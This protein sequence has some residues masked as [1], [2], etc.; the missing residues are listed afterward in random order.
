MDLPRT[1]TVLG[2]GEIL[3]DCFPDGRRPGGAPANQAF[4][5]NQL[6]AIGIVA[7]RVGQDPLGDDLLKVLEERGLSTRLIQ[8]DPELPT[9]TVTVELGP[10]GEPSYEIHE[11]V[12][13]DRMELTPELDSLFGRLDA[14]CFGTLAQRSEPSRRCIQQVLDRA[15]EAIRLYDVNLRQNFFTPE[16]L[17]QSLERA[18]MVKLNEREAESLPQILSL[19]VRGAADLARWLHDEFGTSLLCITRSEQGCLLA[20]PGRV[21]EIPGVPADVK[22]TVGAG[23]A[24]TAALLTTLLDGWPL[25]HAGLFANEVG[26][27][28]ASSAGA[29]PRLDNKLEELRARHQPE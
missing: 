4:H 16:I 7:S 13:W 23:D 14:I 20:E 29:M 15:G 2:L 12:A 24:F 11:P 21:V 25:E 10:S 8:R 3:W 5:A 18:N 17:R 28:V 22:D 6:G 19:G 1:P 27:L 26:S 9:G